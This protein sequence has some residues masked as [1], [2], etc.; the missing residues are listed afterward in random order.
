MWSLFSSPWVTFRRAEEALTAGRPEEAR[1][2]LEPLAEQGYRKAVKLMRAVVLGYLDRAERCLRADDVDCA[3]ADLQAAESLVR[4]GEEPRTAS[5]RKLLTKDGLNEA[6]A[7]LE[8]ANPLHAMRTLGV[9]H[10]RGVSTPWYRQLHQVSTAWLAAAELADKG[11]FAEASAA[12]AAVVSRLESVSGRGLRRYEKELTVRHAKYLVCLPTLTAAAQDLDWKAVVESADEV[13]S[14][15]PNDPRV[16]ELRSQAWGALV[17]DSRE[18][19]ALRRASSHGDASVPLVIGGAVGAAAA[20]GAMRSFHVRPTLDY[21]ADDTPKTDEATGGTSAEFLLPDAAPMPTQF[22]LWVDGVGGYLVCL[23]SDITIGQATAEAPTDI[24]LFAPIASL[25][26][27]IRRD[28]AGHY[29]LQPTRDT[30]LNDEPAT[31]AVLKCG[32]RIA[33]G[34]ACRLLFRKPSPLSG[35]ARL[36]VVSGHRQPWAVNGILLMDRTLIL[37]TGDDAHIALPPIATEDAD[38]DAP[39]VRILLH[40]TETGLAMKCLGKFKVDN[41]PHADKAPLPLPAGIVTPHYAFSV[42]PIGPRL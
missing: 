10:D 24:R 18:V 27:E 13:L 16:R 35:T 5:L 19:P 12:L 42:E 33:L 40:G 38:A 3:W 32:D 1:Q 8:A 37:G 34:S 30:L 7:A 29:V 23:N 9:L 2:L 25:H 6:A 21:Q 28:D 22:L 11:K 14:V 20:A 17:P 36:D 41:R 15:A 31:K 39:E 26:A 4:A